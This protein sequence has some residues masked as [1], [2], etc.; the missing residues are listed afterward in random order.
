[1]DRFTPYL[2]MSLA[3]ALFITCIAS[4]EEQADSESTVTYPASFFAQFDPISV[5]DMLSRIPGVSLV[6]DSSV[7]L[8]G[9]TI[10]DNRRG[11]GAGENQILINGK[12][13]AGKENEGRNQLSRIAASRVDYIEIIRGT[14]GD[15]DVRGSGQVINI[16]L[17]AAASSSSLAAEV[18]VDRYHDGTFVHGGALSYSDQIG[19]LNL[20]VS[21]EAEFN[22]EHRVGN[23]TS[24][25]GDNSPNDAVLRIATTDQKKYSL[26]TNID[27]LIS[28]NDRIHLNAL[29]TENDPP[30]KTERRITDFATTPASI[31]REREDLAAQ[32]DDWEFGGDYE[33]KFSDSGKYK[34]LVIVNDKDRSGIRERFLAGESG[35]PEEKDLFLDSSSRTRER[36]VRTSYTRALSDFQGVEIGFERAQTILDS[37]LALGVASATG[38]PSPAVGGLV[39]VVLP[40]SNS[41]VEEMRYEAF[42]VH[43]WQLNPRMSLESTLLVESSEIEQSG[44]VS[45]KRDFD[46]IRPK[47]DYRFDITPSVQLRAT[48][49]KDVSQLSFSD[50]VASSEVQDDDQDAVSGN[51]E[52]VQEQSW[53]YEL[54]LEYR[55]PNDGGVLKSRF[56][57]H[58]I[59]DVIDRVDVSTT[60]TALDSAPGNIGDGKRYGLDLN[61]SIRFGFI[62]VPNAL[63]TTALSLQDSEVTDP[64]LGVKRRMMMHSRG[65]ARVGYQH[66][67]TALN[68]NYG[69]SYYYGL[70]GNVKRFDIDDLEDYWF[71]PTMTM[72]IEK[73]T[74]NGITF[75]LESVNSFDG[76]R[77]RLRTRYDGAAIDGIVEEIEK[78]CS[79]PG[80][81]IALTVRG[82]I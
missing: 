1:M 13:V 61:A 55:L 29:F 72:F 58:D 67:L 6:L 41:S 64:F 46:F 70:R 43:N 74:L 31:R 27:Y 62:G 44:D 76:E 37:N 69:F 9:G 71:D 16:V 15:M 68:L 3:C 11:L 66:D 48:I 78:S 50:F 38:I 10:V 45:S 8:D 25:H 5:N 60:P 4:A 80:H 63:L 73:V 7:S 33:H 81:T 47:L 40:N 57:Y 52:F 34:F 19:D 26:N 12:R 23:E 49:A 32:R 39:P 54:N 20:L 18:K 24:V 42:A 53:R 21:I 51:P 59:E 2:R 14:S 75:R 22:Y 36:I 65:Y 77:C 79:T 82:T 30:I 35:P 56:F 17:L 28:E